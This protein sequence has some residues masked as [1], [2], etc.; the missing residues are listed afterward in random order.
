MFDTIQFRSFVCQAYVYVHVHIAFSPNCS[1]LS[2]LSTCRYASMHVHPNLPCAPPL[3]SPPLPSPP[4]PSHPIPPPSLSGTS[5]FFSDNAVMVVDRIKEARYDFYG[6]QFDRISVEAKE[7]ISA[8]LQKNPDYRMSASKALQH[9]WIKVSMKWLT[10]LDVRLASEF[11]WH[12]T[13]SR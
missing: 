7:F 2:T 9:D 11:W 4:L 12:F 3:P 13:L 10:V 5:P 1:V 8:L 6:E